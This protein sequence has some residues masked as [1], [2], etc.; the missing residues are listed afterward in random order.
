MMFICGKGKE[1]YL[2][3]KNPIPDQVDQRY[4]KWK[5][6]NNMVM[7]WLI[8]SMTTEIGE[9]F[10][11]SSQLQ[12][13]SGK[14]LVKLILTKKILQSHLK[15]KAKFMS[16]DKGI[17]K[18]LTIL[19]N[20]LDL[21]KFLLGLNK[22]L[23]EVHGRILAIKPLPNIKEIFAKV[24]E[25]SRKKLMLG[26]TASSKSEG[27]ALLAQNLGNEVHTNTH[28]NHYNRNQNYTGNENRQQKPRPWCEYCKK[29]GHTKKVCWDIH[30]KPP[31]W[32]PIK[33]ARD[34]RGKAY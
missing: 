27:S 19:L 29:P 12:A 17:C 31:D 32:K 26:V 23:D 34:R 20:Y 4:K 28:D 16:Y 5:A 25:E 6:E 11:Y 2:S 21:F 30:G 7:S 14:Q 1:D 33:G 9:G 15:L 3:S 10:F 8:N 22:E 24:R 13:K 18:S